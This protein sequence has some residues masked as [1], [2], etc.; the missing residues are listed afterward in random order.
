M[1]KIIIILL[2]A[3]SLTA[4]AEPNF[5]NVIWDHIPITITLPLNQEKII[6]F[7][8]PVELGIPLNIKQDLTVQN[9]AGWLYL[10]A[11]KSFPITRV[12]V[13]DTVTN[14]IILLNLSADKSGRAE[15]VTINYPKNNI[16]KS[17]DLPQQPLQGGLAYITLTRFAEQQLYAPE[18]LQKNPYNIQLVNSYI[19]KK[20]S[21]NQ[22]QWFYGLFTDNSTVNIPWAE[23]HGGDFYVTAVLVRNQLPEPLDLTKNLPLLCGRLEHVWQAVAF[24][25]SWQLGKAGSL[26]DTTMAFLISEQPFEQAIKNCEEK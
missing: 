1:Q 14:S 9:N 7:P 24:F 17:S 21:I 2:M 15:A 4:F 16:Q 25:P 26:N 3:L 8:N 18:R 6:K 12:E 23:W 22:S 10:T 11:R 5:Q 20:G 19:D 13:K